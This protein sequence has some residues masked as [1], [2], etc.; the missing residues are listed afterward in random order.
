MCPHRKAACRNGGIEVVD[1]RGTQ[2]R[3][4]LHC[5]QDCRGRSGP[6]FADGSDERTQLLQRQLLDALAPCGRNSFQAPRQVVWNLNDQ[7][8]H[9]HPLPVLIVPHTKEE[10]KSTCGEHA[11]DPHTH[12]PAGGRTDQSTDELGVPAAAQLTPPAAPSC[13]A[14][15]CAKRTGR[16]ERTRGRR[17]M[18]TSL[19]NSRLR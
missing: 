6:R 9:L 19:A 16:M 2:V 4:R 12:R 15:T 3:G 5:L 13:G 7:V 17:A 10:A 11:V 8:R 14:A 1:V 18:L